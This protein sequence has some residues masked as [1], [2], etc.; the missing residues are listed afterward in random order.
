MNKYYKRLIIKLLRCLPVFPLVGL[1]AMATPAKAQDGP[2]YITYNNYVYDAFVDVWFNNSA[3][4]VEAPEDPGEPTNYVSSWDVFVQSNGTWARDYWDIGQWAQ[5][6]YETETWS[7]SGHRPTHYLYY[8]DEW[9]YDTYL[10]GWFDE[11][12][13][14]GGGDWGPGGP[15]ENETVYLIGGD[16]WN[17][18]TI[19]DTDYALDEVTGQ[20]YIYNSETSG[21]D[22]SDDPTANW[23]HLAV[24]GTL[25]A[26]DTV[27]N[28]WFTPDGDNWDAAD[29]PTANWSYLT[30]DSV[31]YAID[32]VTHDGFLQDGDDWDSTSNPTTNWSYVTIDS[33]E[34][35]GDTV[36]SD[37]FTNDGSN[38]WTT[39]D[40]PTANWVYFTSGSFA[41]AHD[42]FIDSWYSGSEGVWTSLEGDPRPQQGPLDVTYNN[43]VYDVL[44]D[45]W[46][47]NYGNVVE[48]PEDPGEPTGNT[49]YWDIF[50]QSNG[51]WARDYWDVGQWAQYDYE[52][53]TW[54]VSGHRPTHYLHYSGGWA[55]DTYL[56]GWFDEGWDWGGGDWG[57]GGPGENETVYL[58]SGDGWSYSAVDDIDY[59]YDSVLGAWFVDTYV[60]DEYTQ[61]D[62]W[63]PTES[64]L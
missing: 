22:E 19:G 16:D 30:I 56:N 51:T 35:A 3:N 62:I 64:P 32:S 14:W 43:Y 52:N 1:L 2:A 60:Q 61:Q 4:I 48:A 17:Y 54:S 23:A 13:N 36:T 49:S 26:H 37:W 59:A 21:W 44:V 29:D 11:S 24:G 18:S 15:G 34:Y 39:T 7:L 40:N 27:T 28:D 5:Y 6:D 63:E 8:T 58:L 20:W 47:D 31:S 55:Y 45:V 42:T 50:V 9:A 57:P 10:N 12:W 25:Y 53:Q 46:F 33:V 41:F 38:H